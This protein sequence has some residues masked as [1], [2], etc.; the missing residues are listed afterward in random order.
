M[1]L[2][3][4]RDSV[5][6]QN[7]C[8]SANYIASGVPPGSRVL[9]HPLH[10][11]ART[12]TLSL[13]A[14]TLHIVFLASL[15]SW[16]LCSLIRPEAP[17]PPQPQLLIRHAEPLADWRDSPGCPGP[18]PAVFAQRPALTATSAP[19][20][21]SSEGKFASTRP[22]HPQ[23]HLRHLDAA[24]ASAR[25]LPSGPSDVHWPHPEPGIFSAQSGHSPDF[26]P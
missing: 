22:D 11:S 6:P 14:A 18:P 7:C 20:V 24:G 16:P 19:P 1:H 21:G 25:R 2:A 15:P 8:G 17:A 3:F 26:V 23:R 13:P 5:R 9:R 4:G 12:N 10:G